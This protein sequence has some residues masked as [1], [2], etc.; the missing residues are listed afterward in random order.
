MPAICQNANTYLLS[1]VGSGAQ[2]RLTFH[3]DLKSARAADRR[4]ITCHTTGPRTWKNHHTCPE[5]G[6]PGN[7]PGPWLLTRL[8][9]GTISNEISQKL[10]DQGNAVS[11]GRYYSSDEFP[12]AT[13]VQGGGGIEGGEGGEGEKGFARCAPMRFNGCPGGVTSEQNWPGGSHGRLGFRLIALARG[14]LG[15]IV[16]TDAQV[17]EFQF[18]MANNPLLPPARILAVSRNQNSH[19][20]RSINNQ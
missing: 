9:V 11:S 4:D 5:V 14:V 20:K 18:R 6:G 8:Q 16:P 15:G 1:A 12:P 13:W 3:Y 2:N 10:D 17:I 7:R 19:E